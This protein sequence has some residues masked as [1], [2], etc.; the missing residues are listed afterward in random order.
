MAAR[1]NE[2]EIALSLLEDERHEC[3]MI[4]E[5]N[6]SA[7]RHLEPLVEEVAVMCCEENRGQSNWEFRTGRRALGPVH[8]KA[9][10]LAYG[11]HGGQMLEV[12][13]KNPT[14]ALPVVLLRLKAKDEEWKRSRGE[15]S[16]KWKESMERNYSKS[17]DHRSFYFKQ[18]DR[19]T[20]TSKNLVWEVKGNAEF[21]ASELLGYTNS[22][23]EAEA[24]KATEGAE[25]QHSQ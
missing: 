19:K 24:E 6:L 12:L 25:I 7:I 3:D 2:Y 5:N 16:R 9:I 11:E 22:L 17:L 18:Q 10:Q 1:R 15:L 8:V 21:I 13:R 23:A 14:E 4:I 20:A